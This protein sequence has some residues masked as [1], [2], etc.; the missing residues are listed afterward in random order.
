MYA[1]CI[2]LIVIFQLIQVT[3]MT[4]KNCKAHTERL[5][6]VL[7]IFLLIIQ[8]ICFCET[9]CH[10]LE[11]HDCGNTSKTI[12]TRSYPDKH[13]QPHQHSSIC[14]I[15]K[16]IASNR[17]APETTPLPSVPFHFTQTPNICQ[18]NTFSP[19]NNLPHRSKL[20]LLI[21]IFRC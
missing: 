17:L 7:L 6:I 20:F 15:T 3:I 21:Q 11:T 13:S 4:T 14:K 9:D 10:F 1:S 12:T 18:E 16:T 5:K 8:S 19:P 2:L